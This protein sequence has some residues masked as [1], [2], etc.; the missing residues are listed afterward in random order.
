MLI[1]SVAI[2]TCAGSQSRFFNLSREFSHLSA[3]LAIFI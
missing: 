3:Q 1:Q 2:D